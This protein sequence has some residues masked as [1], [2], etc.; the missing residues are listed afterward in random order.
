[1]K[2]A[3][4][5]QSILNPQRSLITPS[6]ERKAKRMSTKTLVSEI[7]RRGEEIP[8]KPAFVFLGSNGRRSVLTFSDV[9]NLSQ[10]FAAKLRTLG[11]SIGDVVCN[12]LPTS[13]ERVISKFTIGG[14]DDMYRI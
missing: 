1:M 12:M 11:I 8:E 14:K 6:R 3:K 5:S 4:V 10:K 7:L 9:S 13:P 2:Q